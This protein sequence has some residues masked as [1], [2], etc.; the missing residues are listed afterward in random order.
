TSEIG[1]F[2][3][4]SE[5]SVGSGAR[6]IEALTGRKA[7]ELM[8]ERLDTLQRASSFLGVPETELDRK[9]LALMDQMSSQQKEI[10]RLREDLARL[11]FEGL[12]ERVVE[13]EG[14]DVLAVQVA[15][16]DN[17]V[18][19]QMTDWF[20]DQLGSGVVV[21]GAAIN[22]KPAFVA[23]V[24]DDL[25][26]RGVHA[27]KLVQAVAKKVGGGGG[28][29]PN[30]AQ[31]GGVDLLGMRGALADVPALVAEQLATGK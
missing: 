17:N 9:V 6:R 5:G 27:G 2:R 10:A 31:A 25:V 3:I 23:A 11:E 15:A 12:L 21:L 20:R 8:S 26:K 7:Q 28:G 29:R 14:V 22:G 24:T 16:A 1:I 4:V 30:L 19:R 18:M 13:V